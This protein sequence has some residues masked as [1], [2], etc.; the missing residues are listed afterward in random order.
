MHQI[1]EL[2]ILSND[3]RQECIGVRTILG[4]SDVFNPLIF[5]SDTCIVHGAGTDDEQRYWVGSHLNFTKADLSEVLDELHKDAEAV[6]ARPETIAHLF[7][8]R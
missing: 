8:N 2:R 1:A 3:E 7:I 5:S 6:S 4:G